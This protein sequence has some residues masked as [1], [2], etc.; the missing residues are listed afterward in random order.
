MRSV[1]VLA[2]ALALTFLGTARADGIPTP[3]TQP[4]SLTESL[5]QDKPLVSLGRPVPLAANNGSQPFPS[6]QRGEEVSRASYNVAGVTA[7]SAMVAAQNPEASPPTLAAPPPIPP[8]GPISPAEQYNCG[9]ATT[10]PGSGQG[11]W[12]GTKQFFAGF[13]WIG[14]GDTF[15]AGG[16][17]HLFESDHCFDGFISPVTNPFLFE[18]P[19]SLTEV[20]PIF[21]WQQTPTRNSVF[22]GGDI[23]FFGLQARLA[24][25]ERFSVV[26]NELGLISSEPHNAGG[27]FQ[28]HLGF[29][30]IRIG[31]KFTF[32]RNED[33]GTLGAVGLTFEIP[34]GDHGVL[35]DTGSLSVIPYLSFG[36]SFLRSSYGN[37]NALATIGYDF[38]ADNQRSDAFFTS[39]HLDYALARKIYPFVELNWFVYTSNG[40]AEPISFEGRDLFNFGAEHVAGHSEVSI[41]LGARYKFT[42]CLQVG[43]AF[44]IP[45]TNHQ[46]LQDFR[47]TV[48]MIFRF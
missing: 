38:G 3:T 21:M 43:A 18:D 7:S 34:A 12:E 6:Q 41:A 24:I 46:D 27:D 17:H 10:A 39:L 4:T 45:L 37:F 2:A 28:N 32:L 1:W 40:K 42:E 30:Q 31:P 20:R 9:V 14:K 26:V 25:T 33:T 13:P 15:A 47:V 36:Q 11:F 29:A 22:R 19:R 48:D 35:Q 23:E 5:S 16:G 8:S 44:E